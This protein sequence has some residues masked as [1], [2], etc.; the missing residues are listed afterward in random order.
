M[1]ATPPPPPH[2]RGPTGDGRRHDL[3][4]AKTGSRE[5]KT[6]RGGRNFRRPSLDGPHG[7]QVR[8]R[9]G[10]AESIFGLVGT[11]RPAEPRSLST[12][13]PGPTMGPR[14]LAES[15]FPTVVFLGGI[16]LLGMIEF[17]GDD[18]LSIVARRRALFRRSTCSSRSFS[19]WSSMA[20]W[21]SGARPILSSLLA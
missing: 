2:D 5:E 21:G 20:F 16:G 11:E 18:L 10:L 4:G 9:L 6:F 15:T 7:H 1:G 19:R 14:N 13:L 3:P 17:F 12:G 8:A